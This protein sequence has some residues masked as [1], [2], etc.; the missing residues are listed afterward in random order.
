MRTRAE[1][2]DADKY[3]VRLPEGL[4]D[5]LKVVALQNRR[6]MNSEIVFH[7]ER[8]ISATAETEKDRPVA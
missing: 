3:V 6:S 1:R 7:L 2:L 5:R 8:A 4:R